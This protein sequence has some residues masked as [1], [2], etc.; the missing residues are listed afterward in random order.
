M[1]EFKTKKIPTN[2]KFGNVEGEFRGSNVDKLMNTPL[3]VIDNYFWLRDDTRTN[4]EVLDHIDHQNKYT[5]SIMGPHKELKYTLYKEIKSY[6]R[7][8]YDSYKYVQ[9]EQS[10]YKYFNRFLEGKDYHLHYRI[11]TETDE[12]KLLLDINELA[13]GKNQCDITSFSISPNHKYMSYGV[14]YDGSEKYDFVLVDINNKQQIDTSIPKL[15]YCSYFWTNNEL[16]YYIV[17]DTRNRLNELWLYN[18]RDNT[19]TLVYIED[20]EEYNLDA[21]LT[22][23]EK[24]VIIT[25]GDYDS[26]YSMYIDVN[27]NPVS[28]YVIKPFEKLVKYSVEHHF[29]TFYI[30]TNKDADN[31]K[32]IKCNTVP[33]SEWTTFIP[34]NPDV[35][36]NDMHIFKAGT[37]LNDT[38]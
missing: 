2:V 35:Y 5:D 37:I 17:G 3:E 26:N 25:I 28:F 23:D 31:W 4:K 20:N 34:Y 11:N 32:I 19:K 14:D 10:P 16:L 21:Y 1:S 8:T 33:D 38:I 15:A 6:I 13:L 29:D 30:L 36:I 7:E 9:G 24:Y 18:I 27:Q 22:S 12:E